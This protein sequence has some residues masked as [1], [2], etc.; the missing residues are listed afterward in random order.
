MNWFIN[1]SD[2]SLIGWSIGLLILYYSVYFL[3]GEL[4]G[5]WIME[6]QI[7]VV[8]LIEEQSSRTNT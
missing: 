6:D 8:E 7:S 2:D 5:L 4:F 1:S 3:A